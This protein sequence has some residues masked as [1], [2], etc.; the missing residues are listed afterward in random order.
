MPVTARNRITA[1]AKAPVTACRSR[2]KTRRDGEPR[3]V[4]TPPSDPPRGHH[5]KTPVPTRTIAQPA[6]ISIRQL[7]Q[8]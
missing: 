4:T 3:T 2:Q 7:A 1:A 8:K 6:T 5:R